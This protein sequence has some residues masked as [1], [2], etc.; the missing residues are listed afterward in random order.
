MSVGFDLLYIL[1]AL[2]LILLAAEVFINAIEWLGAKLKLAEGAVGSVLAAVGTAL[3]ETMIPIVAIASDA[4]SGTLGSPGARSQHI[5]VGAI[6]GAPFM[7]ATL[8]FCIIALTY[9]VARRRGRTTPF[10]VDATVV[11]HDLEFFIIAFSLGCGAGVLHYYW[12]D[13]PHWINIV[14]AVTLIGVYLFYL[15]K[16]V[17]AGKTT[18]HEALDPL[19]IGR[20]IRYPNPQ[21][22]RKRLIALQ[23]LLA[24][25]LMFT[26]AHFFVQHFQHLSTVLGLHPLILALL[27]VP[28][29]TELPE[30]FNTI[31]WIGRG[32]DTLAMGN[33][34]GAMVFQST[35]PISLGLLFL[36][37]RFDPLDPAIIS[38][39]LGILGAVIVLVGL[40]RT[41]KVSVP[42]LLFCGL[43]WLA[44]LLAVLAH[45]AGYEFMHISADA[46]RH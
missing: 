22:P 27:I 16:I 30:K 7:L 4:F 24:L 17:R 18:S 46:L 43:L 8:A 37:W 40:R 9:Y 12:L 1:G 2:A 36:D 15:S 34:S 5:G 11:R 31:L 23:L 33:I 28:V 25:G 6:V 39:G 21:D 45:N 38:A 44:F 35:F 20:Y 32:K 14:M 29:A 41:N 19:H 42:A 10:N 13:M 26:G 3:P